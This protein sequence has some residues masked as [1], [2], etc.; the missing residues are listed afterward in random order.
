ML[1]WILLVEGQLGSE[2]RKYGE[3][4]DRTREREGE[5]RE[6]EPA[7]LWMWIPWIPYKIVLL[8]E[9][10]SVKWE[11]ARWSERE[12]EKRWKAYW[13][14]KHSINWHNSYHTVIHFERPLDENEKFQWFFSVPISFQIRTS[15]SETVHEREE[16]NKKEKRFTNNNRSSRS[17]H[18]F[19]N[20]K[21]KKKKPAQVKNS[22]M[23]M[24]ETF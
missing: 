20:K 8:C 9:Q 12:T 1:Y 17:S 10:Y 13:K 21:R 15:E 22:H 7:Q 19:I 23:C 3:K 4:K 11:R 2:Y 5:R 24:D 18:V 16:K 6:H 14:H